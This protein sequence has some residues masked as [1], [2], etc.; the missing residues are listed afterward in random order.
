[1][2]MSRAA[3]PGWS[4]IF[5]DLDLPDR[6]GLDLMKDLRNLAPDCPLVVFSG[7]SETDAGWRAMQGGAAAFIPKGAAGEVV[8]EAVRRVLSGRRYVSAEL[9]ETLLQNRLQPRSATPHE[10]LSARELEV[11]RLIGRGKSVTDIAQTLN[12]SVKTVSTYRGR[13]LEKLGVTNTP[14]LIRYALTHGLVES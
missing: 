13:I 7:M 1:D 4:I 12:L 6:S 11:L 8:L 9:A 14:G 3:K 2:G 10:A 5:L